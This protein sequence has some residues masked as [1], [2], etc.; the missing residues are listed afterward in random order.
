MLKKIFNWI[1]VALGIIFSVLVYVFFTKRDNSVL[2]KKIDDVK[3]AAKVEEEKVKKIEKRIIERAKK[4]ESRKEEA[5]GLA[6]RLK[7]HFS[8]FIIVCLIISVGIVGTVSSSVTIEN[9]KIPDTYSELVK[10]YQ[11]LAEITIGYQRLYNEAEQALAE[12]EADN[13]ALM[14]IIKNLQSLMKVQQDIINSLL[15]K[16]RFSVLGGINYVPLNPSYSG[17]TL[18]I[19]FEF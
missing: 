17:I 4:T 1:G 14:E 5:E 2:K 19:E 18:G 9:L 10:A 11:D 13:K 8:I 16:N 7:K 12:S 6:E 3:E 15:Q